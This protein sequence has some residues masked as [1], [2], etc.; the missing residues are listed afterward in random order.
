MNATVRC[1]RCQDSGLVVT[2]HA[3]PENGPQF[4]RYTEAPCSCVLGMEVERELAKLAG[5]Y[6]R[7]VDY[8]PPARDDDEDGKPFCQLT[9]EDGNAFAVIGR[10]SKALTDAGLS[11]RAAEFR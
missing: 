9:G 10:V 6:G 11:E 7:I 5:E 1:P 2:E 3:D 4:S 8:D